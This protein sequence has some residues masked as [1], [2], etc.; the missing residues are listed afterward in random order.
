MSNR[1]NGPELDYYE[2]RR[3]HQEYKSRMREAQ[4]S[5][6]TPAPVP[7][8]QPAA[9]VEPEPQEPLYPDEI[10]DA[11]VNDIPAEAPVEEEDPLASLVLSDEEAYEDDLDY[12]DEPPAENP[13]PFDSF[14][15][16]F[17]GVKDNISARR[18]AKEEAEL[19]ALDEDLTDEELAELDAEFADLTD[20]EL[21][22]LEEQ[23]SPKRARR[24]SLRR[25]KE[26]PE[27]IED[28]LDGEDFDGEFDED[29]ENEDGEY[30][31]EAPRK[32]GF[33][34]FLNLFVA[35]VDDEE[36]ELEEVD[37]DMDIDYGADD[38]SEEI[39]NI[40]YASGAH[41]KPEGGQIMDEMNKP[42]SDTIH[43]M[44]EG[45][46]TSGM[47]RRERRERAMRLAAEEAARKAEE[48]AARQA[49]EEAARKAMEELE[50][51]TEPE[52]AVEPLFADEEPE[53][54]ALVDEAEPEAEEAPVVEE[55]TREFTPVSLRAIEEEK[56]ALFEVD[57]EGEDAEDEDDGDDEDDEEDTPRRGLFG[58]LRGRKRRDED[59]EDDED[60]DED[61]DLDDE[62]V[63]EEDED[64]DDE[65]E[66]PAKSRRGL[67]GRRKKV[68]D[69]DDEDDKYEDDDED[70]DDGDFEDDE[71]EE[72]DDEYDEYEDDDDEYDEYDDD[73][74]VHHSIGWHI[75]G[76]LKW[77]LR[78][79]FA[80]LIVVIV[81]NFLYVTG[82]DTIVPGMH[83]AMGDSTAFHL[84]FFGYDVRQLR[85]GAE[86]PAVAIDPI[87]EG[88]P[89]LE[90][91]EEPTAIPEPES[92]I[93]IPD[94]DTNGDLT[95]DP[96]VDVNPVGEDI[97]DEGAP[98]PIG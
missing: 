82:T 46:E 81:L 38:D 3:R 94:F 57:G 13:N 59:E 6:P 48:E 61:D 71:E 32:S 49:E 79:I 91:T 31:D 52:P 93:A 12:E 68:D 62:D 95:E 96:A 70:E 44:A 92:N 77:V 78:I 42:V 63:D 7:K 25:N 83:D 16:F 86:M 89:G 11:P 80:L 58:L 84:L 41:R 19:D 60:E 22:E 37:E 87:E 35:R 9:E 40:D 54:V 1:D 76:V 8:Q 30:E 74:E 67:F 98:A 50:A 15:H 88:E 51:V 47:S 75:V 29:G 26:L 97:P 4:P 33:K 85:E 69:D 45:L 65:D 27:D 53:V 20:E 21:E 24:F 14:I 5:K 28:D 2:L 39:L 34:R 43:Q 66:R 55:P 64:D 10:Q 56:R 23:E 73:D 90:L 18:E 36:L 72:D 17:R